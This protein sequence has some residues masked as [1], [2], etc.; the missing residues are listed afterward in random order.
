MLH[1]T[2]Q[3][4]LYAVILATKMMAKYHSG[5][6]AMAS[7][8]ECLLNSLMFSILFS[9]VIMEEESLAQ[10]APQILEITELHPP[11]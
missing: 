8:R 5:F 6:D 10:Q 9:G 2:Y 11:E 7:L 4:E 3:D 1:P